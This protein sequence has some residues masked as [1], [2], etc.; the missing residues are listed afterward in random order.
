MANIH[1]FSEEIAFVLKQKQMLRQWLKDAAKEEG[2]RI[3]EL[4]YIFCSDEYLL[5]INQQYL[6]HD[7]Y[8]DIVTFD[9]SEAEARIVGDI[10]ISVER[11]RENAGTFGVTEQ[12]ELHR[13]M[14]HGVLH[15]CGYDDH[16]PEE[17]Q[18]MRNKEDYYLSRRQSRRDAT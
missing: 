11:V 12:D 3:G 13:V 5:G 18:R 6:H 1:F 15:L 10:F 17:K 8:T 9:N 4:N 2:F 7:T 14:I 16:T